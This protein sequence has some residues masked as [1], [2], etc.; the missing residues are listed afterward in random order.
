MTGLS[1][2]GGLAPPPTRL[3]R[4]SIVAVVVLAEGAMLVALGMQGPL[5]AALIIG[6]IFFVVLALTNPAVA[7]LSTIAAVPFSVEILVPGTGAAFQ[8]PTEPMLVLVVFLWILGRLQGMKVRRPPKLLATT[9]ALLVIVPYVSCAYSAEPALSFKVASNLA[10][11]VVFGVLVGCST[12][13]GIRDLKRFAAVWCVPALLASAYYLVNL[14]RTSLYFQHVNAAARPLFNEHGTFAAYLCF[15]F[16]MAVVSFLWSDGRPRRI[17]YGSVTGVIFAGIVLSL[18]RAAWLGILGMI[19]AVTFY[20]LRRSRA[21]RGLAMGVG[22]GIVIVAA[23]MAIAPQASIV[24][25]ALSIVDT[26]SNVSNL[27]RF[28]RWVAAIDMFKDHPFGGVGYGAYPYYFGDYQHIRLSTTESGP[29]AGAHSVIL[30]IL[31]E[32]G[33]A[34]GIVNLMFVF[35]LIVIVRRTLARAAGPGVDGRRIKQMT[36]ALGAGLLA[37]TIHGMFNYYHNTDKV[38]IPLWAFVGA[39]VACFGLAGER[40]VA[41][42]TDDHAA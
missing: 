32:T 11:Y 19:A 24:K 12:L 29:G 6:G 34:G 10:L 13:G 16:P 31:A 42:S 5:L 4:A 26:K 33:I 1:E 21:G 2:S 3:V 18:T 15:A 28:N 14:A 7:W 38:N 17:W 20:L 23:V 25:H 27:E 39:L 35:G 37:Y 36:L 22:V 9:L 41:K 30:S 8:A 40:E